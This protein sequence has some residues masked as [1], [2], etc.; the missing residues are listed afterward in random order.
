[1]DSYDILRS[2][3]PQGGPKPAGAA[4]EPPQARGGG[5]RPTR[6]AAGSGR[7]PAPQ[8][9]PKPTGPLQSLGGG[10]HPTGPAATASG[11]GQGP[12]G[13]PPKK[14]AHRT[15]SPSRM[16]SACCSESIS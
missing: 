5:P 9:G 16:A 13:T 1:M 10:R 14:L 6:A 3:A 11:G 12:K 4:A 2:Q 15:S 7:W 8:G